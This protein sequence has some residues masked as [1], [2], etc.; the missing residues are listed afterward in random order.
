MQLAG[1]QLDIRWEDRQANFDAVE[2][3]LQKSPPRRGAL[4]A[5]PALFASGFSMNADRITENEPR[6]TE[7]FLCDLARRYDITLVG[8]L[9]TIGPDGKGRNHAVVA[10]ASGRIVSR[11]QKIH[12]FA[13]GREAQHYGGGKEIVVFRCNG[14]TVSAFVCYDLRFPEIF[15]AAV[16]RGANLMIVIANWPAARIEHWRT[17]LRARA[18]ENQ[19]YV[20]GVNR[21]GNDPFLPYPGRSA[22]V[23][24]TGR[25][26]AEADE[27][28]QLL[29]AEIELPPLL[30][31][32]RGL[33]FL[34]D[35]RADLSSMFE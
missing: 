32:R 9:A 22:I 27:S 26:L 20:M 23:D 15:R 28:Q 6:T 31:Y 33:P 24:Y 34:T 8:G 7:Q 25:V 21:C 14:F 35:A 18:I 16:Q 19:C 30:E 4:V 12:P 3:L 2:A 10:D 11:Y 29:Q 5:L 1:I 13:P 17:L